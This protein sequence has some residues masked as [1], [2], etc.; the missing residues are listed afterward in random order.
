MFEFQSKNTESASGIGWS[1]VAMPENGERFNL[2][3][4]YQGKMCLLKKSVFLCVDEVIK[5]YSVDEI[6]D[7]SCTLINMIVN[8]NNVYTH[9]MKQ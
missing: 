5:L 4:Y 6:A 8:L 2:S 1:S 9:K 7:S 3:N